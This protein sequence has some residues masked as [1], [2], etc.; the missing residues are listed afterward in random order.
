MSV[1]LQETFEVLVRSSTLKHHLDVV[2]VLSKIG[3]VL[4][5][6]DHG[7]CLHEGV[8]WVLLWRVECDTLIAVESLG[9]IVG[10]NNSEDSTIDI[11]V[12]ADI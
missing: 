12:D 11:K 10:V 2:L 3:R 7:T 5:H 6:C 8:V 4:L 9:E 1:I